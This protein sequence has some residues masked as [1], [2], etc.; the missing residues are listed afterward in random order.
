MASAIANLWADRIIEGEARGIAW[1]SGQESLLDAFR[2][3]LDIY[4][5]SAYEGFSTFMAL[6][7]LSMNQMAPVGY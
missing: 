7:S 3:G 2:Q 4:K 1:L 5:V 6:L